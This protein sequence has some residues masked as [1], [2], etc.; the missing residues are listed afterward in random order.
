MPNVHV[1]YVV[2]GCRVLRV[3]LPRCVVWACRVVEFCITR[4]F[5]LRCRDGGVYITCC[6][7]LG[8]RKEDIYIMCYVGVRGMGLGLTSV[9]RGSVHY[10]CCV[11][12]QGWG[13]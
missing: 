11:E 3:D 1:Q 4:C 13:S 12:M 9:I 5:V 2:Y 10:S 6:V 8:F 7:V